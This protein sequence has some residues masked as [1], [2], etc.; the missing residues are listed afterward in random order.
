MTWWEHDAAALTT[1]LNLL[2]VLSNS[3]ECHEHSSNC[4]RRPPG[5]SGFF[6]GNERW[7]QAVRA[8]MCLHTL[9]IFLW[10]ITEESDFR[11]VYDA[12][13]QTLSQLRINTF[14]KDVIRRIYVGDEI[15]ELAGLYMMAL[16]TAST[17]V[18]TSINISMGSRCRGGLAAYVCSA[19]C[20]TAYYRTS[21]TGPT[22]ST[23]FARSGSARTCSAATFARAFAVCAML[24][25]L[26]QLVLGVCDEPHWPHPDGVIVLT[27]SFLYLFQIHH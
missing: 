24:H 2:Q 18:S 17:D 12:L 5:A 3:A 8:M 7:I 9:H 16:A 26:L 10:G 20:H 4:P 13:L 27:F 15:V 1:Y 6:P 25:P 21:A 23:R 11:Q 22:S 14:C 19:T